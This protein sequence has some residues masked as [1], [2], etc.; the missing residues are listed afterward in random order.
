MNT[1]L[2]KTRTPLLGLSLYELE[3][4]IE[5]LQ[6]PQFRARQLWRSVWRHGL[7]DFSDMTD[8]AN[9]FNRCCP[10]I[11][12]LTDHLSLAAR[13]HQMGQLSG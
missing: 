9:L 4:Q 3:M 11:F 8:L 6:L 13:I 2:P 10:S 7:T 1:M 12:M 5:Q